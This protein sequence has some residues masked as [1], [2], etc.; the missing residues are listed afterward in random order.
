MQNKIEKNNIFLFISCFP[1]KVIIFKKAQA[2][3]IKAQAN[4]IGRFLPQCW[5]CFT[6]VNKSVWLMWVAIRLDLYTPWNGTPSQNSQWQMPSLCYLQRRAIEST[7]LQCTVVWTLVQQRA[8]EIWSRKISQL[9]I[10]TSCENSV[11]KKVLKKSDN[12]AASR[13]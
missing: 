6:R 10:I 7:L 2:D 3:L 1:H 8:L 13:L 12:C 4:H 11:F 5:V 9:S